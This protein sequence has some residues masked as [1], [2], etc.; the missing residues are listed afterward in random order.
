MDELMSDKEKAAQEAKMKTEQDLVAAIQAEKSRKR[1]M[2]TSNRPHKRAKHDSSTIHN[3]SHTSENGDD[4]GQMGP[5]QSL[6]SAVSGLEKKRKTLSL[7][8][9]PRKPSIVSIPSTFPC[10]LC[11][12]QSM[13]D[14]LPVY[15]PADNVK[16]MCKSHDGVVR[17]HVICANSVPEV[18]ID[19]VDV[20][21]RSETVVMNVNGIAK[22]RWS[23]VSS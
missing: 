9:A 1:N 7:D 8:D 5:P 22:A 15:Q 23:L 12:H 2:A 13:D 16:A 10:I 20:E 14:L 3:E 17:A 11:P 4:G 6:P 21:G 19:Q 18:W